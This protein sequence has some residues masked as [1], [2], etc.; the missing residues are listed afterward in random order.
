M[1]RPGGPAKAEENP[2]SGDKKW[3]KGTSLG[4]H[5]PV[6]SPFLPRDDDPLLADHNAHY[7]YFHPTFAFAQRHCD[8]KLFHA[9]LAR[10]KVASPRR[11]THEY[12]VRDR[13]VVHTDSFD[14]GQSHTSSLLIWKNTVPFATKVRMVIP[15]EVHVEIG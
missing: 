14:F 6:V 12:D 7:L 9:L 2:E 4:V 11:H 10:L 1:A 3:S 13:D 8:I 15:S 5:M